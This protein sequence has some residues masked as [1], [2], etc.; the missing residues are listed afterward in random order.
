MLCLVTKDLLLVR[1]LAG[2]VSTSLGLVGDPI[3]GISDH[4]T[5]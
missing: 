4:R 3:S 1:L 5:C 2:S